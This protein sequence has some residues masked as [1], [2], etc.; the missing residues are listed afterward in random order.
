MVNM[1][2]VAMLN[3]LGSIAVIASTVLGIMNSLS[4]LGIASIFE[5]VVISSAQAINLAF[6]ATLGAMAVL[7][8]F[9]GTYATWKGFSKLGSVLGFGSVLLALSSVAFP[10][11]AGFGSTPLALVSGVLSLVLLI[12]GTLGTL[13]IPSKPIGRKPLSSLEIS[14]IATLSALTAAVTAMTGQFLPSPTGGYTHIGDS[15]IYIA[16]LLL[17]PKSGAFIGILGALGADFYAGYPRWFISI[18]AHGIQGLVAGLGRGRSPPI[19]LALCA[20]GGFL[21]ASTYFYVNLFIKGL[22]PAIISYARDLFGQTA[23]SLAVTAIVLP[24]LKRVLPR[25]K[26]IA[27]G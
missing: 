16:S 5:K 2:W 27:K 8:A 15:V 14:L 18:P 6:H 13:K 26:G 24:P 20:L 17:G 25:I 19:Q 12:L 10:F 7:F 11:Q 9:L 21:M 3:F 4:N 22:G 23:F 1:R